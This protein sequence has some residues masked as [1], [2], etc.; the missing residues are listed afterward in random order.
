MRQCESEGEKKEESKAGGGKK[1]KAYLKEKKI[2]VNNINNNPKRSGGCQPM[3]KESAS[4]SDHSR[5][6]HLRLGLAILCLVR[7]F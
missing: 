5:C 7:E 6:P 1:E 4:K 2:K 3:V